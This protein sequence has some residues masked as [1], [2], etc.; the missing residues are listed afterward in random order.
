MHDNDPAWLDD[1]L[2]YRNRP[3]GVRDA[4]AGVADDGRIYKDTS[5][6]TCLEIK[7]S[8]SLTEFFVK[9]QNLLTRYSRICTGDHYAAEAGRSDL[10]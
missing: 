2:H 9:A 7:R 8:A 4:T 6:K 1:S 5:E 10:W 3:H